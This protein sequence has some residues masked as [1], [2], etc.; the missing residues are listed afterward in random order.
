MSTWKPPDKLTIQIS[1]SDKDGLLGT[2]AEIESQMEDL[3]RTVARLKRYLA[4]EETPA[5]DWQ[6]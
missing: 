3:E 4:A 6:A 1:I 2:I 5:D